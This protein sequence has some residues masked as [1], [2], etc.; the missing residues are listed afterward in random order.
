MKAMATGIS[1]DGKTGITLIGQYDK[2]DQEDHDDNGVSE[3]PFIENLSL[4]SFISQDLSDTSNIQVRISKVQSEIFGGPILGDVVTSIGTALSGYDEVASEQLFIDDDV[5]NQY[6]GKPWE[7]TEWI[8][9][10]RDEAFDLKPLNF[11]EVDLTKQA[12]LTNNQA[13]L[14]TVTML[15]QPNCSWCKK[16]GQALAKAFEQCA[17][18][19]NIAFVGVKGNART[20]KR[21]INHYHHDIPAYVADRK[22]LHSIGGF[23]AS[24]TTIIYDG[25]GQII[26]KKRGFIPEDNLSKAL[27][28]ISQGECNI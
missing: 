24:P 27:S 13:T 8:N 18:S 28:I 6:I 15:F 16:Q 3:A 20:L 21:E 12:N 19:I 7:T 4:T 17:S 11:A 14:P 26:T 9:T 25:N 23:E 2:Q 10:A 1:D 5:R 22:F